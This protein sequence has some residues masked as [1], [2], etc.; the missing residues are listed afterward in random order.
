[1]T[2][3]IQLVETEANMFGRGG[4][5]NGAIKIL[6]TSVCIETKKA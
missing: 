2:Y 5:Q 4:D 6:Q 1:M 3:D